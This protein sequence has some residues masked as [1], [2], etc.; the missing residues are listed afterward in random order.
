LSPA[1]VE[2]A[3]EGGADQAHEQEVVEVAGLQRGVLAVV[4]EAEE[5]AG[6]RAQRRV[7]P[8]IQRRV[9]P[10]STVVAELRPSAESEA[11][12]LRSRADVLWVA[13]QRR[14]KRKLARDEPRPCAGSERSVGQRRHMTRARFR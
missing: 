12:R 14:Q 1:R 3:E 9:L 11:R 5:L 2:R 10:T 4:G 7:G 6:V 8:C 13:P